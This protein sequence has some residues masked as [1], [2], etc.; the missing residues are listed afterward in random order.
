[1]TLNSSRS[2][3]HLEVYEREL[4]DKYIRARKDALYASITEL[5]AVLVLIYCGFT[6]SLDGVVFAGIG[7]F[8][9]YLAKVIS[10]RLGNTF[11]HFLISTKQLNSLIRDAI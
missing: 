8:I 10:D 11:H 4:C 5:F 3:T 6:S 1:M 2:E 9:A 7:L